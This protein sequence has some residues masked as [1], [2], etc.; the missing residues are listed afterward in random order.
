MSSVYHS[1]V[2][3]LS[4]HS[5]SFCFYLFFFPSSELPFSLR[6]CPALPWIATSLSGRASFAPAHAAP[7]APMHHDTHATFFSRLPPRSRLR[8]DCERR[9]F[10]KGHRNNAESL[11]DVSRGCVRFEWPGER[12]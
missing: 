4:S 7:A 8:Q 2:R 3:A 5:R 12:R 11:M 6:R 10:C 9:M 1:V